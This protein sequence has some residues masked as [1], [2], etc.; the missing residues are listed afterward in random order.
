MNDHL[1]AHKDLQAI[2]IR[3]YLWASEN[4]KYPLALFVM[5]NAQKDVFLQ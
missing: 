4:G 5:M 2:N 3:Q 1:N